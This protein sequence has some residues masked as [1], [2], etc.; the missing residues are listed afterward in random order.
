MIHLISPPLFDVRAPHLACP[1]LAAELGRR[2]HAC[3]VHDL[4]VQAINWL[5]QPLQLRPAL[6]R[7]REKVASLLRRAE[8]VR[9]GGRPL[10]GGSSAT[11]RSGCSPAAVPASATA[12]RS[13]PKFAISYP[14]GESVGDTSLSPTR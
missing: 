14:S 1:M 9:A 4:N 7:A 5:L 6:E 12:S 13:P 2:G 3:K 10:R 11:W 8:E